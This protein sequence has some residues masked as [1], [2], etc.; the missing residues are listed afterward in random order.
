MCGRFS[1]D[2]PVEL[3]EQY[4]DLDEVR[5]EPEVSY[6]VAPPEDGPAV[7]VEDGARVL[8]AYRWGLVPGWVD[9]LDFGARTVN[10]RSET[11]A[12]KPAFR[13][14]YRSRRC[15]VPVSGFFEWQGRPSGRKAPHHYRDPDGDPLPLAGLWERWTGD[16]G[17]T[18]TFT[19]LTVDANATVAPVHDRMPVILD[20]G[21]LDRWLDPD[22]EPPADVLEPAPED[23]LV[24]YEVT[25]RVNDSA[26]EGPDLVEPREDGGQATSLDDFV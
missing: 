26:A 23:R 7:H 21:D 4:F 25:D 17:E 14:A 3:L 15:V 10:A 18:R 19:I 9:D 1:F 16:G 22:G 11:V 2:L 12:G 8:D 24:G 6:N 5:R 20:R 13:E